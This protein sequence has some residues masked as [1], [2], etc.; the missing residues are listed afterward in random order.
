MEAFNQLGKPLVI[1]GEGAELSQLQSIAKSNVKIL[2]WQPNE[3]VNQYMA[4]A[5]AFVYAAY[6]D[7]GIAPV[8]AQACGTP[9][10]AFGAGGTLE[11]VRDVRTHG[12]KGTGILFPQQTV[13]DLVGAIAEFEQHQHRFNPETI[14][15]HA[16]TFNPEIFKQRYMSF[17]ERCY[18]EFQ[19]KNSH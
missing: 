8:E 15:M 17:L 2:G 9:V 5:K 10:I 4:Q 18:Q 3:V 19:E 7:F 6:E 11:T 16:L 13:S 1:I 12:E 14:R